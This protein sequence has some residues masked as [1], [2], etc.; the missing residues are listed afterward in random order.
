MAFKIQDGLVFSQNGHYLGKIDYSLEG[1]LN[2]TIVKVYKAGQTINF[3]AN[4]NYT[5][6]LIKGRFFVSPLNLNNTKTEDRGFK[7]VQDA[8]DAIVKFSFS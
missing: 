1:D 8:I 3:L 4:Q 2:K 7:T 6:R 5:I